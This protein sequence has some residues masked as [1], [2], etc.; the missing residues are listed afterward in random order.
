MWHALAGYWGGVLPTSEKMKK[1][2][3]VL[4]Y[5]IQSEGNVGNLRDIAMDSLEKYGVGVVDPE[6]IFD[7]YNDLHGYLSSSGID[8]VKVDVQN[9]LETLGSGYGGR[10]SLTRKYQEALERSIANNFSDNNLICCMSH[11]SDSI[12]WYADDCSSFSLEWFSSSVGNTVSRHIWYISHSSKRSAAARASEDFMPREPTFQTLHIASVAFNSLLLGEIV[13]PDW[14]M[15]HVSFPD[16]EP[17]WSHL[18]TRFKP[19]A[20]LQLHIYACSNFLCPFLLEQAWDSRVPRSSK[21]DRWL[22]SVCKVSVH[23]W[24]LYCYL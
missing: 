13:V 23:F 17:I 4:R 14:D 9:L 19:E 24:S 7:F 6:K 5:P 18:E 10:V 1:Y 8:G 21:S 11:N 12:Y 20:R 3:P 22:C 15:F 16:V 2:D